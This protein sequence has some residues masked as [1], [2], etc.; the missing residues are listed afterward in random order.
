MP[1]QE[2][3]L[4]QPGVVSK[5]QEKFRARFQP[6]GFIVFSGSDRDSQ[7]RAFEDLL[8][9]QGAA[10]GHTA[11]MGGL[12][13][14][15]DEADSLKREVRAESGGVDAVDNEYRAR[16]QYIDDN[17]ASQEIISTPPN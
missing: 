14:M 12:Q 5:H 13:A 17:R 11:R 15:K 10:A 7:K 3:D 4:T 8:V 16:F 1:R 9:I 2:V 6:R